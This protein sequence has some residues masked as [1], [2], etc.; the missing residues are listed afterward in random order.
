MIRKQRGIFLSADRSVKMVI[1]T[2]ANSI[3]TDSIFCIA[4]SEPFQ[5]VL[6]TADTWDVILEH[7]LNPIYI[8]RNNPDNN[9]IPSLY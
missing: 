6:F 8:K 3:E 4:I 1:N 7:S 9:E 5:R 2:L